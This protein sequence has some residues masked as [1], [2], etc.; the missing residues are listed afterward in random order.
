MPLLKATYAQE[1]KEATLKKAADVERKLRNMGLKSAAGLFRKPSPPLKGTIA[2]K[3]TNCQVAGGLMR[4]C[5]QG[6]FTSNI[7]IGSTCLCFALS[8]SSTTVLSPP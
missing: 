2:T 7:F 6:T 5:N 1:D 3:A 8:T 4:K